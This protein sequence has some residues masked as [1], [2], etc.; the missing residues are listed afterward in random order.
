[1]LVNET[2]WI[3]RA[4]V[5]NLLKVPVSSSKG[6][7]TTNLIQWKQM[8]TLFSPPIPP[9]VNRNKGHVIVFSQ[10]CPHY[11]IQKLC[12]LENNYKHRLVWKW[13]IFGLRR[14]SVATLALP[15]REELVK[16]RRPLQWLDAMFPKCLVIYDA[17]STP[18]KARRMSE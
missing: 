2:V 11:I 7:M 18:Q 13:T 5:C 9:T 12:S 16:G 6:Q 1:M 14:G 10:K 17:L 3:L 15:T 8:F 4:P